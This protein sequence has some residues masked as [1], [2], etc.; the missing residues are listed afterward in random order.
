VIE[1]SDYLVV[2]MPLTPDTRN[3]ITEEN[4]KHAKRSMILINIGRGPLI[5]EEGLIKCL[6]NGT[7]AGAALDVFNIEPLPTSSKIW[8]LPN[9]LL[10]PHNADWTSECKKESVRFFTENCKKFLKLEELDSIVNKTAG[11]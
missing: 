8:S 4:L 3:F 2:A 9:V 11:Y 1:N 6:E 7:I 5:E 10:S